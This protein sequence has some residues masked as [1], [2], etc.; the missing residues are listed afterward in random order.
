M[1][2]IL[3][4]LQKLE[5][6]REI[7]QA[8]PV[9]VQRGILRHGPQRGGSRRQS[10]WPV[11]MALVV[12]AAVAVLATYLL[13]GGKEHP[14]APQAVVHNDPTPVAQAAPTVQTPAPVES[15]PIPL[16]PPQQTRQQEIRVDRPVIAAP[17]PAPRPQP[18]LV[19]ADAPDEPSEPVQ[20]AAPQAPPAAKPAPAASALPRFSVSGIGW[21]ETPASRMAMV[22]GT[23]VR[24]GSTISGARVVEILHDRVRFSYQHRIFEV[25]VGDTETPKQ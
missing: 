3:K 23:S 24:P 10:P 13:L 15:A 18:A 7:R 25:A 4:A 8:K 19:A 5:R 1:S 12:T 16:P 14:A 11:A 2:S 17:R 22:N 9:D 6:D 20:A 21:N